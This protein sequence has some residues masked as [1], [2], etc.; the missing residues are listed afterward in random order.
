MRTNRFEFRD[1]ETYEVVCECHAG[2]G[3]AMRSEGA[4]RKMGVKAPSSNFSAHVWAILAARSAGLSER[5]GIPD[6]F[7]EDFVYEFADRYE[8]VFVPREEDDEANPTE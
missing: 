6:V 2:Q 5:L 4:A 7:G 8:V 1:P 3:A